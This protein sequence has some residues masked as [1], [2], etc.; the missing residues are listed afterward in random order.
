MGEGVE[1]RLPVESTSGVV[2]CRTDREGVAVPTR[3]Q[4]ESDDRVAWDEETGLPL[5]RFLSTRCERRDEPPF[6]IAPGC[7]KP[8][9]AATAREDPAAQ[10]AA[11]AHHPDASR[12]QSN[13]DV[14]PSQAQ[15]AIGIDDQIEAPFRVG[16]VD[17]TERLR[18][19]RPQPLHP[20]T[21]GAKM[22]TSTSAPNAS[23]SKIP[24]ANGTHS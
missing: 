6:L 13:S 14:G 5:D 8:G 19:G 16:V 2:V 9:R 18:L 21:E 17:G 24:A 3:P 7:A 4:R 1:S 11:S 20:S 12:S 23:A 22:Y 15:H 10:P